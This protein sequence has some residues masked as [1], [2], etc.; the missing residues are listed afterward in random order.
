MADLA[1][2]H[3][4]ATLVEVIIDG[5][6]QGEM[7]DATG[8]V[9]TDG[10]VSYDANASFRGR[11]ELQVASEELASI[12][13]TSE[14][15]PYGTELRLWRGVEDDL[16]SLGIFKIERASTQDGVTSISGNDRSM[17]VS[18]AKLEEAVNFEADTDALDAI[19]ELILG[20][21]PSATFD[22]AGIE[23]PL[24]ALLC[25]EGEDPWEDALGIAKSIG[26]QLYANDAG[27]FQLE[28]VPTS[29]V[30]Q[31]IA[32]LVEGEGGTLLSAQRDID[33]SGVVNKWIVT[34]ENTTSDE[35]YRGEA[36][37]DNPLSPTYFDGPFGRKPDFWSSEYIQSDDQAATAAAAQ[38]SRSI[39]APD[40][41]TFSALVNPALRPF[42]VVTMRRELLGL[43]QE[44]CLDAITLPLTAEG[45][46]GGAT[47]A[48]LEVEL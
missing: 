39:G 29:V 24:P 28:P 31:S 7:L 47:R 10:S 22:F 19:Q 11:M 12:A 14:L 46:M 9:V 13:P 8:K 1:A 23:I 2:S 40:V 41:I 42:D 48:T 6:S 36:K 16:T 33:R 15:A 45:T 27:V 43:D 26:C 4:L 44:H 30:G 35:V 20:A 5:E 18:E 21:Y 3:R 25:A 32:D 34:G 37:D 38:L 17:I